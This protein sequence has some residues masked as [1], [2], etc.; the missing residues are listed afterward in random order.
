M[1]SLI[2]EDGTGL[3][4][5]NSYISLSFADSYHRERL[6][7]RWRTDSLGNGVTGEKRTSAILQATEYIDAEFVFRG[8]ATFPENP[9]VLAWPRIGILTEDNELVD[10]ESLPVAVQRATA[11]M[12]LSILELGGALPTQATGSV[13]QRRERVGVVESELKFDASETARFFPRVHQLLAQLVAGT[14]YGGG[15]SPLVRG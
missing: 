12:A 6:N 1:A 3:T 14:R 2:V 5:A 15:N 9:Q 4:T 11:E 13:K 7:D 10:S 8:C